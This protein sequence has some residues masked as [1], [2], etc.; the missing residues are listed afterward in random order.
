MY[1]YEDPLLQQQALSLIPVSELKQK[2]KEACEK[3]KENGQDGV[4]EKDCLFLEV[5]H[6]FGMNACF[7]QF[8]NC[9]NDLILVIHF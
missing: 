7:S 8:I 4:D 6:W 9:K 1:H 5:V 2:A 3:S